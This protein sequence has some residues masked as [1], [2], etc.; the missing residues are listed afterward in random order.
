MAP[1]STLPLRSCL[2]KT[3]AH[4]ARKWTG[5]LL[6]ALLGADAVC[7]WALGTLLYEMLSGLPPFYDKNVNQM[8]RK[9]LKVLL[10]QSPPPCLTESAYLQEPLRQHARVP[11]AAFDLVSKFLVRKPDER[12]GS[13]PNDFADIQVCSGELRDST[14]IVC[15]AVSCILR[16][17]RLGRAEQARAPCRMGS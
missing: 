10:R 16:I 5:A 4:T 13:G 8:Y 15:A 9:I 14:N 1:R 17:C 6:Q 11:A 12:L 2:G 7:R 3:A